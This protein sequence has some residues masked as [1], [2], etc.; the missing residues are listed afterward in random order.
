MD[1]LCYIVLIHV[2]LSQNVSTYLY[3]SVKGTGS[4]CLWQQLGAYIIA[5]CNG[6]E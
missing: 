1:I 6:V 2:L 3:E 4:G 5:D